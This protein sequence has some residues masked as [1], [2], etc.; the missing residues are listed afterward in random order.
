VLASC[1][2]D[3]SR[4]ELAHIRRCQVIAQAE[5]LSVVSSG[6]LAAAAGGA[7]AGAHYWLVGSP[8]SG[9]VSFVWLSAGGH[10]LLC[11][12]PRRRGGALSCAHAQT[13]RLWLLAA[14]GVVGASAPTPAPVAE[15]APVTQA[16]PEGMPV[17]PCPG[18]GELAPVDVVARMGI[19][20][21]CRDLEAEAEQARI[22]RCVDCGKKAAVGET[23]NGAFCSDC[24]AK[25]IAW[26]GPETGARVGASLP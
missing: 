16:E 7:P 24:I 18:C 6:V 21:D 26:Y 11:G 15:L 3:L 10:R 1:F 4:A 2:A 12:C 20:A 9:A 5:R 23:A 17:A 8:S 25:R 22:I 14:A 13:V 19:C